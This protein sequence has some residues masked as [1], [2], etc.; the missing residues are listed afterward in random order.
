MTKPN[1]DDL[2]DAFADTMERTVDMW[3]TGANRSLDGLM[4]LLTDNPTGHTAM[5]HEA[6]PGRWM[7]APT[8]QMLQKHRLALVATTESA[9][10][11]AIADDALEPHKGG[12]WIRIIIMRG[13]EF[14]EHWREMHSNMN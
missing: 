1:D 14:T 12:G 2:I 8:P 4:F 13:D 11:E 10:A 9:F 3:I 6:A 7:M 5:I